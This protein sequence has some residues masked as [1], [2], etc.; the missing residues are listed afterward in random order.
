MRTATAPA[1]RRDLMR[2]ADRIPEMLGDL[3]R[4]PQVLMHGDASPQN[5]LVPVDEPESFVA[6]D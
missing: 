6:I 4:V 5:L 1:L 2:L 3:E